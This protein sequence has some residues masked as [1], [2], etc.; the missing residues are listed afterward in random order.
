MSFVLAVS[1]LTGCAAKPKGS[2]PSSCSSDGTCH[3]R[4]SWIFS[5]LLALLCSVLSG[6]WNS[7]SVNICFAISQTYINTWIVCSSACNLRYL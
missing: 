4:V 3:R 6:H 1:Q 2:P 5:L 7:S